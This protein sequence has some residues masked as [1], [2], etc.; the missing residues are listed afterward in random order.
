[1]E[2]TKN[3]TV[4]WIFALA[5]TFGA[6][7]VVNYTDFIQMSMLNQAIFTLSYTILIPLIFYFGV[8]R[9][10]KLSWDMTFI[11]FAV[12]ILAMRFLLPAEHNT[13]RSY[14]T[15][16]LFIVEGGFLL[17][18]LFQIKRIFSAIKDAKKNPELYGLSGQI[19]YGIYK[20][21][22]YKR[23]ASFM[24]S[25]LTVWM[26]SI[27]A[28]FRKSEAPEGALAFTVHKEVG[29]KMIFYLVCMVGLIEVVVVHLLLEDLFSARTA[30]IVSGL[31]IYSSFMVI[32]DLVM[33]EVR[34]TIIH[35]DNIFMVVGNRWESKIPIDKITK[36]EEA[37]KSK[38]REGALNCA[39]FTS[40]TN[41][42]ITLSEEIVFKTFFG[43]K[44]KS[45][46]VVFYVDN[47]KE[48]IAAIESKLNDEA[49][50]DESIPEP[51]VPSLGILN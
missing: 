29:Y 27:F 16:G 41:V 26:Y 4:F 6:W 24:S 3:L 10:N 19:E 46:A 44:K 1:M 42:K 20:V 49:S 18:M 14:M 50:D 43:I 31:T 22:K 11:V 33:L 47:G 40:Q 15:I 9:P 37:K 8:H 5:V 13:I 32:A 48:F 7:Y 39:I 17:W 34:P 51:Q 23:F 12:C 25:E 21:T 45:D 38:D 30:W 28:F 36:I 2:S 35:G